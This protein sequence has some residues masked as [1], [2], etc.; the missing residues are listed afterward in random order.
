M[1]H[2]LD[3]I[4]LRIRNEPEK[5]PLTGLPFSQRGIV[6]AYGETARRGSAGTSAAQRPRSR[7]EG[8]WLIGMGCA[9][10]TYPYYRMPGGAARLTIDPRGAR[11]GR[12]RRARD[13]HGHRHGAGAGRGRAART[14]PWSR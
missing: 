8:D 12:H 4:E 5:D 1:K 10:G 13:G 14:C 6:Q 3:P 2:G 9:T 7:R 11:D